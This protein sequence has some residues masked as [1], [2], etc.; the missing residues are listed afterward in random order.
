VRRILA[1]T[2]RDVMTTPAQ[3][4]DVEADLEDVATLM[5][6]EKVNPVPVLEHGKLVGIISEA[7]LI[8]HLEEA[9][10]LPS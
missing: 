9:Q 2:A 8:R 5:V 3:S 7:D 1:M 10:P 4:V 6:E